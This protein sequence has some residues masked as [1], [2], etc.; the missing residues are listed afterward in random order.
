M[1]LSIAHA[2]LM[3]HH[4]VEPTDAV[5][6]AD[7]N[8]VSTGMD[9]A[10][11]RRVRRGS[12]DGPSNGAGEGD[13][14]E[15]DLTDRDWDH[16][17]DDWEMIDGIHDPA[18]GRSRKQ[19]RMLENAKYAARGMLMEVGLVRSKKGAAAAAAAAAARRKAVA[20]DQSIRSK[21]I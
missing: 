14:P 11:V 18:A 2:R 12:A 1:R 13:G 15:H 17:S 3:M 21:I 4:R 10:N 20:S 5:A 6:A 8:A 19:N 16:E 9:E 7:E